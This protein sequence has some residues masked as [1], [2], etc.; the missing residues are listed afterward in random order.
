MKKQNSQYNVK[1]EKTV[2]L[3]WGLEIE[4]TRILLQ[5]SF[6]FPNFLIETRNRIEVKFTFSN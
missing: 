6:Q 1:N 3:S 5:K 2:I 4:A